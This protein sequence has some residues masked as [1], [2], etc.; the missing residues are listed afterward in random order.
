MSERFRSIHHHRML[1]VAAATPR[2]VL[3]PNIKAA[4]QLSL[5]DLAGALGDLD[6]PA[7]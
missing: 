5:H 3:V 4:D 7:R 2:G 6:D 1:R